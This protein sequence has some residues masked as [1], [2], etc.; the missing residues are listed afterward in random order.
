MRACW[1]VTR[2]EAPGRVFSRS[3]LCF[4][5]SRFF[6]VPVWKTISVHYGPQDLRSIL[7]AA[8]RVHPRGSRGDHPSAGPAARKGERLGKNCRAPSQPCVQK[9]KRVTREIHSVNTSATQGNE[10]P[11]QSRF[12][13]GT[14]AFRPFVHHSYIMGW[15]C[16]GWVMGAGHIC[17]EHHRAPEPARVRVATCQSTQQLSNAAPFKL[18]PPTPSRTMQTRPQSEDDLQNAWLWRCW[19][20]SLRR[21]GPGS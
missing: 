21:I 10:R 12:S 18:T 4:F 1:A 14:L 19:L 3:G 20:P 7:D 6:C 9:D 8:R 11:L 16:D 13:G 5:P 17:T 2:E 15:V